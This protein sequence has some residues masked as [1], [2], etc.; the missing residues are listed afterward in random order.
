MTANFKVTVNGVSGTVKALSAIF[1]VVPWPITY[2]RMHKWGWPAD[3]ALLTPKNAVSSMKS[4][5]WCNTRME[6]NA[7]ACPQCKKPTPAA[8]AAEIRKAKK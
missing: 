3:K 6:N 7:H 5:E 2:R 1:N 4:C 8:R